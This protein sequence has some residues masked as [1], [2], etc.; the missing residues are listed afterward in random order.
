MLAIGDL[1]LLLLHEEVGRL[2]LHV[3]LEGADPVVA[4]VLRLAGKEVLVVASLDEL[5][6]DRLGGLDLVG[7]R[8]L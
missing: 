8:V 6:V 7:R 4:L 1:F 5:A 3:G 2:L